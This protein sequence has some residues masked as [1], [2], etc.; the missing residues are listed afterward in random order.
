MKIEKTD[1]IRMKNVEK[2]KIQLM[3]NKYLNDKL[4]FHLTSK[5]IEGQIFRREGE[6]NKNYEKY[7]D[8]LLLS[9]HKIQDQQDKS[10]KIMEVIENA[11]FC[12]IIEFADRK[13]NDFLEENKGESIKQKKEKNV[14]CFINKLRKGLR[15]ENTILIEEEL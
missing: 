13:D 11:D 4:D 7:L 2:I 3:E 5:R 6:I 9:L 15:E 8:N 14:K 1:R 12:E 10:H